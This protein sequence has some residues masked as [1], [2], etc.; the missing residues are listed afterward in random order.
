MKKDLRIEKMRII[1]CLMVILTHVSARIYEGYTIGSYNWHIFNIYDSLSRAAVPVFVMIS[2][3]L[4]L[5]NA[6]KLSIKKIYSKYVPKMVL[7]LVFGS[8]L[9]ACWRAYGLNN[10]DQN[11]KAIIKETIKGPSHLWYISVILYIYIMAPLLRK[12]TAKEDPN[13]AKYCY[14]IFMV[15]SLFISIKGSSYL[16]YYKYTSMMFNKIYFSNI[17]FW[18]SYCLLGYYIFK[19]NHLDKYKWLSYCLGIFGLISC[20]LLTAYSCR[21]MNVNNFIYYDNFG[22]P[23]YCMAIALIYLMKNM[24]VKDSSKLIPVLSSTT[25]GIYVIHMIFVQFI[26]YKLNYD[27]AST[28]IIY[29]VPL[30][31]LV[32][33]VISFIITFIYKKGIFFIKKAIKH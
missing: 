18:F 3:I 20:I 25:L 30:M 33:F 26:L 6:K 23:V 24:K 14:W 4:L 22:F 15:C 32:V 17:L 5:D 11:W 8:L 29:T 27:L 1:A 16:P 12:I 10:I 31:V 9:Y 19:T 7:I 21:V 13:T 2:G 28:H